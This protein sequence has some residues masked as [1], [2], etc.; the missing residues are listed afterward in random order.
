[1]RGS[2]EPW[3]AAKICSSVQVWGP[4]LK[5]RGRQLKQ[6]LH[7]IALLKRRVFQPPLDC[8]K[9]LG[10][11]QSK[12]TQGSGAFT[13][14]C[15]IRQRGDKERGLNSTHTP[16]L[17]LLL[18]LLHLGLYSLNSLQMLYKKTKEMLDCLGR[19]RRETF[20]SSRGIPQLT[21]PTQM[22]WPAATRYLSWPVWETPDSLYVLGKWFPDTRCLYTLTG[23][24][25]LFTCG[26]CFLVE[27]WCQGNDTLNIYRTDSEKIRTLEHP[28]SS[29]SPF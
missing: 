19:G 23:W 2:L 3:E 4:G 1:M 15:G 8:W 13:N 14:A 6:F 29:S 27:F 25:T 28:L 16:A 18:V 7:Q 20:G 17:F 24:V 5:P 11:T 21:S 22:S 10:P 9:S 26:C 12:V